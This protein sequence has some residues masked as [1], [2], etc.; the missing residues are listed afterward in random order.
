MHRRQ[1]KPYVVTKTA[2]DHW[3]S[4]VSTVALPLGRP[5]DLGCARPPRQTRGR[6]LY[7]GGHRGP[8]RGASGPSTGFGLDLTHLRR[9]W[10]RREGGFPFSWRFFCLTGLLIELG[11]K[12]EEHVFVFLFRP[13]TSN[14]N[15]QTNS[16][17]TTT[18]TF[19]HKHRGSNTRL[20]MKTQSK[21]RRYFI[22]VITTSQTLLSVHKHSS[23][24]LLGGLPKSSVQIR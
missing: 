14:T 10:E 21:R 18:R 23:F 17:K 13:K 3:S 20:I 8:A 16:P 12:V 6:R 7:R 22:P 1:G 5:G 24:T 19:V 2:G 4:L 9:R 11:P 15:K